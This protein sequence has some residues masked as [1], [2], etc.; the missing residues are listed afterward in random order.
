MNRTGRR[1]SN[2]PPLRYGEMRYKGLFARGGE[3]P[4]RKL[5][6]LTA[7]NLSSDPS[8]GARWGNELY[9]L[10]TA[11]GVVWSVYNL[12]LFRTS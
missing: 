9:L 6:E 7:D 4:A 2:W 12:Y 11:S 8:E 3:A 10:D 1:C 5:W